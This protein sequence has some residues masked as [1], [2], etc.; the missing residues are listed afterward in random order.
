[1]RLKSDF[2][3]HLKLFL[4]VQPFRKKQFTL[5]VG[6]NSNTTPR[7]LSQQEGRL[8]SATNA[9]RVAVAA[10]LLARRCEDRADG[11]AVWSW[12]LDAG[13]KLASEARK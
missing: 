3:C 6:Q 7:I 8:M 11:Q 10:G 13:V 9:G 5:V 4:P 12:H 1:V 2:S